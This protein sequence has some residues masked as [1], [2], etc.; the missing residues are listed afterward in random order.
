MSA[1]TTVTTALDADTFPPLSRAR[2]ASTCVPGM[3]CRR[4][5][6]SPP[7]VRATAPSTS[8]S[9]QSAQRSD[10]AFH[11]KDTLDGVVAVTRNPPGTVGAVRSGAVVAVSGADS[12][13]V[14]PAAS[15]ADTR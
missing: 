2:T 10:D 12:A 14:F 6:V 9:Y 13:D 7:V 11:A 5:A 1:S 15:A 4:R 3:S 8:T